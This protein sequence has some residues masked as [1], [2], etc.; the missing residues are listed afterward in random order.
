MS[1]EAY[2]NCVD[3]M[4]LKVRG[5]ASAAACARLTHGCNRQ[6]NNLL[7]GLPIV[8]DTNSEDIKVGQKARRRRAPLAACER[9]LTRPG[10]PGLCSLCAGAFDV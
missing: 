10:S 9:A 3:N 1:E 5:A 6:D 4:R 8:L 7:F 2:V